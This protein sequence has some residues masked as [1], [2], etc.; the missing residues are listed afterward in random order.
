MSVFHNNALL[1]AA[2]PSGVAAFDT[3]L[4]PKSIFFEGQGTSG[5][6]MTR[7]ST[8]P[9]NRNRWLF[10]AWYH[11]LRLVDSSSKRMTI[12][13]VSASNPSSS[14]FYLRHDEDAL[15]VFHRDEDGTEGSITTSGLLQD[16]TSWYHIMVDYDSA[17]ASA[18]DR[19]SLYVNGVRTGV[20][21][22]NRPGQNKCVF[23]NTEGEVERI[24]MDGSTII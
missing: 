2:Q 24:G 13:A 15:R 23:V 21:N 10:G 17:N 22:S 6:S 5:D 8:T 4:I 16:L 19:I 7:T 14:G 12:F 20:N 11:P 18:E 3:T 9:D 1:G